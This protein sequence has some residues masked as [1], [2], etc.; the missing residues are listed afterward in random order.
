[1]AEDMYEVFNMNGT[2]HHGLAS[3]ICIDL[4]CLPPTFLCIELSPALPLSLFRL[5][6]LLHWASHIPAHHCA[7]D[8]LLSHGH[9][10]E[11]S[12]APFHISLA[13][14]LNGMCPLGNISYFLLVFLPWLVLFWR[15]HLPLPYRSLL[16]HVSQDAI[17]PSFI[18]QILDP[19]LRECHYA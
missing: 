12:D 17:Y 16:R 1:M 14:F 5:Q 6:N 19:V 18:T 9:R 11:D 13:N 3:D 4:P 8:C 15:I 7:E 10:C 2:Y